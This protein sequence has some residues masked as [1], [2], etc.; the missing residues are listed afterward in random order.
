[1]ISLDFE[2]FFWVPMPSGD[3]MRINTSKIF[4]VLGYVIMYVNCIMTQDMVILCLTVTS[5]KSLI[6]A[7][8]SG[9]K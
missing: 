8:S 4:E 1:M 7:G 9:N 3:T 5:T 2:A 6:S